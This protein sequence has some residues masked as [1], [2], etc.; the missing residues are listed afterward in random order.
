MSYEGYAQVLCDNGHLYETGDDYMPQEDCPHCGRP[1]C[2]V[3]PVNDTNCDAVGRIPEELFKLLF[4]DKNTDPPTFFVPTEDEWKAIIHMHKHDGGT[5]LIPI[6]PELL[7]KLLAQH[8]K[9]F[10]GTHFR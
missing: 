3:N 4:L 7:N 5:P 6:H 8:G 1:P 9:S 10:K 2:W